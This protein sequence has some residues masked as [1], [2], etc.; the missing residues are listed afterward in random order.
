MT[1]LAHERDAI[2]LGQGYP[3][4]NGPEF[5]LNAAANAVRKGPNQYSPMPGLPVMREAVARRFELDHGV[6][7]DPLNEVTVTPG[8]TGAIA[9]AMLGILE[10]G[11]EVVLLEPWYDSYP[12]TIEMA[13]ATCR[14]VAL[15]SPDFRIVKSRLEAAITSKTRMI[16][17][18]T[19]HNPTGRILD[20]EEITTIENLANAHDLIIFSDEVYEHLYF[21]APHQSLMR[22]KGLR[23]RTIVASSIGKT[24]SLT[25]WKI[26]WTIAPPHLTAAVRAAHQFMIFSVATPLQVASAEA[27]NAPRSYFQEFRDAYRRKRELMVTG[28]ASAGLDVIVPEGTYFALIDHTSYGLPDDRAFCQHLIEEA[29]VAAIPVSAFHHDGHEPGGGGRNLVRFAFCKTE[30]VLTQAINQLRRLTAGG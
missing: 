13:G 23:D 10:P 4:F 5:V 6:T 2:N 7:V 29:G 9:A 16:V 27:L 22:R 18:N 26:G 25:G 14:Y 24:F 15:E 3:D 30:A 28:L 1:A 21:E 19:P 12:A 20:E 17:V 11:D 8:C